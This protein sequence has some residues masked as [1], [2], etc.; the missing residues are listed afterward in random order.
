MGGLQLVENLPLSVAIHFPSKTPTPVWVWAFEAPPVIDLDNRE[1]LPMFPRC[2]PDEFALSGTLLCVFFP[3][4]IW[5][6]RRI[7]PVPP[8]MSRQFSIAETRINSTKPAISSNELSTNAT[9]TDG[10][11]LLNCC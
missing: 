4:L 8:T 11:L 1:F 3:D 2:F 9:G 7:E 5:S 10:D 6:A